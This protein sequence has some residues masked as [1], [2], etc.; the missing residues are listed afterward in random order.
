MSTLPAAL[1]R[2]IK[3]DRDMEVVLR[4]QRRYQAYV[5]IFTWNKKSLGAFPSLL[6][7]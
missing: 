1:A 4:I 7:T 2:Q 6:H 5:Y 3:E